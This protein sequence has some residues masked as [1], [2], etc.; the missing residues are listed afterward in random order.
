MCHSKDRE[1]KQFAQVELDKWVERL[2]ATA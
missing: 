2:G 1:V